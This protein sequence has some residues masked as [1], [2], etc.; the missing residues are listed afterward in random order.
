MQKKKERK[1]DV[2]KIDRAANAN[3]QQ[4]NLHG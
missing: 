4:I 2:S 3:E 1:E